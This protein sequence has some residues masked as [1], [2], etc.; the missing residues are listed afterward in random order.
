MSDESVDVLRE[1]QY[2][3][4]QYYSNDANKSMPTSLASMKNTNTDDDN[5]VINQNKMATS[6]STMHNLATIPCSLDHSFT[7]NKSYDSRSTNEINTQ[8]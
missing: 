7:K 2:N 1:M 3:S 5:K 4:N 6:K 8:T